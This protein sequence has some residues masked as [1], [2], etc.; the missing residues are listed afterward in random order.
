MS[1]VFDVLADV[2]AAQLVRQTRRQVESER[3]ADVLREYS[4]LKK[5]KRRARA[6]LAKQKRRR[7]ANS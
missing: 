3:A 4:R 1:L 6:L 5:G 2:A 7:T